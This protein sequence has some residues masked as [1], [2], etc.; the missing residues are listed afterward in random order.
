MAQKN[1]LGRILWFIWVGR[2]HLLSGAAVGFTKLDVLVAAAERPDRTP[3]RPVRV[4]VYGVSD[5]GKQPQL[6]FLPDDII[7]LPHGQPNQRAWYLWTF[8][9]NAPDIIAMN[10]L[11]V[12]GQ[13]PGRAI[14]RL[15]TRYFLMHVLDSS[16]RPPQWETG[17]LARIQ[18]NFASL[19]PE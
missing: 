6:G 18:A 16:T 4:D 3:P 15:Y 11:S 9:Q 2:L 7:R 19:L 17:V 14:I 5:M 8:P 1:A 13:P 10:N 12:H